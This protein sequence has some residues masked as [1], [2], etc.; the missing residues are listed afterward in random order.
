MPLRG[1]TH[2]MAIVCLAIVCAAGCAG[3][4]SA[5]DTVGAAKVAV[6]LTPPLGMVN[7]HGVDALLL[8]S[9][10]VQCTKTD[11]DVAVSAK[12]TLAPTTAE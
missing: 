5:P 3:R 7:E 9:V 11:G 8:H 2:K 1:T 12:L 4:E 10:P 6:S